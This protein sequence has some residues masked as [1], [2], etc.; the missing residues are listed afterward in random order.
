MT[1]I[2]FGASWSVPRSVGESAC[3]ATGYGRV[4][5][6]VALKDFGAFVYPAIIEIQRNML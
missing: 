2:C 1:P 6:C 3:R 5:C 4:Y